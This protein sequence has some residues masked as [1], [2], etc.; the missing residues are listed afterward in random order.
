MLG[1]HDLVRFG[2]LLQRVD[3]AEPNEPGYWARH[4]LAFMFQAAYSGPITR[5]YGEEIGDELAN[6]ADR[7]T[8]NCAN[9]GLCDDHVARTSAKIL[10][11]TVSSGQLSANQHDLLEFHRE[12]MAVREAYPALSHGSRQHLYSDDV[13]FID[14][15]T[16]GEQQIVFAMNASEQNQQI[17]LSESLFDDVTLY[18]WDLI[19]GEQVALTQ[20]YLDFSLD[21]L[22][23]RY[24]LLVGPSIFSG[25]F[26]QDGDVDDHDYAIWQGA[27]G[28]ARADANGDGSSDAADY[29]VWR[30]HLANGPAA[31]ATA[32]GTS[33]PEPST[34]ALVVPLLVAIARA[35]RVRRVRAS[36]LERFFGFV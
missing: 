7:V 10:G 36:R 25:D 22:S 21:P 23:G 30:K 12:L 29:V 20:G 33:V 3:L 2:D 26:D 4:K 28:T 35:R 6:Y 31:A 32:V 16:H 17:R 24:L 19:A 27:F 34:S 13:L 8:S 15:K 5:Y 1:N 9:L 14:L 18:A 11:V